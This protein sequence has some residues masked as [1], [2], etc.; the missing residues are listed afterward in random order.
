[1]AKCIIMY[2]FCESLVISDLKLDRLN[3][4]LILLHK[5]ES[6]AAVQLS[7]ILILCE[8]EDEGTDDQLAIMFSQCS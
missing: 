4:F 6:E 8:E 2:L 7:S 1:M 5:P 3:C